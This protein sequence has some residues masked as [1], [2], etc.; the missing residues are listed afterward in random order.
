[1]NSKNSIT[2]E[3]ATI[4]FARYLNASIVNEADAVPIIR[5]LALALVPSPSCSEFHGIRRLRGLVAQCLFTTACFAK[6]SYSQDEK[7]PPEIQELFDLSLELARTCL[8]NKPD[9]RL[10]PYIAYSIQNGKGDD[11]RTVRLRKF[12]DDSIVELGHYAKATEDSGL[13]IWPLFPKWVV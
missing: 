7:H 3:Q 1:M 11:E 10:L 8:L 4:V 9:H 13:S 6:G 5:E 12:Y 2:H